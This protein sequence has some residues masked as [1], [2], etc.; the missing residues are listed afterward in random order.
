MILIKEA[1]TK[2]EILHAIFLRRKVLVSE[3]QYSIF[4][5]ELDSYDLKSKVYIV[6]IKDKVIGT[7][8]VWRNGKIFRISRMAIDKKY[9]RKGI[10]SMLIKSIFQDFKNKGLY[11]T[12]PQTTI[13]FYS[14]LGFRKT[15]KTEK[16]K[17]HI[18]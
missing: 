17:Y 2:D 15:N 6:K 9:R 11:L 5:N 4:E 13:P 8:R 10:G 16:G 1:K 14:K 3:Y 18:Y 7:A 12:A